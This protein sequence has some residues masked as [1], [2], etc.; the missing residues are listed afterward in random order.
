MLGDVLEAAG[1]AG[2]VRVVTG[3]V[4]ATGLA[5]GLGAVVVPDPGGGQ[6]AAVEAG[7]SGAEGPCLVVNADLPCATADALR[8]LAR[9]GDA[10]VAAADGTT[11][12]LALADRLRFEPLYGPGSAA[13]FAALGLVRVSIPELEA[14]VDTLDDLERLQDPVGHRTTLVVNHH[15]RRVARAG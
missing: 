7:L 4:D 2:P 10:F 1:G 9:A 14:D 5:L 8:R 15:K 13:R 11:N 12:A 3:D 6:A